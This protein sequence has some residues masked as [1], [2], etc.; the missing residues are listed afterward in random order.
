M[1]K[2]LPDYLVK[3]RQ[4]IL[5]AAAACFSRNG[6]HQTSMQEIC[7]EADLSPGAIYRYFRS[8]EDIIATIAQANHEAE[9]ALVEELKT[10][11]A[12]LEILGEVA[13]EFFGNLRDDQVC[14]NI[15]LWAE[16]TRNVDIRETMR[17]GQQG[18]VDS[19]KEIVEQSQARGEINAALDA[20]AIARVFCSMFQGYI[21]QR[22]IKPDFDV[23]TYVDACKAMVGGSFWLA[24][25]GGLETALPDGPDRLTGSS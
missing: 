24:A 19:F 2:V 16:A 22:T 5:D 21:L 12:T 15:D 6:F 10:R 4:Q 11:G 8:K 17:L 18:I 23:W 9:I 13:N 3:R 20:E 25:P 7:G 14:L 1:P